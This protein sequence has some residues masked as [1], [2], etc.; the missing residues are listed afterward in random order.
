MFVRRTKS[1]QTDGNSYHTHRLV[2]SERDGGRVRQRTLLN[3]GRHFDIDR[4]RTRLTN[5]FSKAMEKHV[6][7]LSVFFTHYSH[8][9]IHKTLRVTP[10]MEAGLS[11]TLRDTAWIA[12]LIDA[13]APKPR[14]PRT[15]RKRGDS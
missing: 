8:C 15:Y 12:G 1:R 9:R 4:E 13:R 2:R 14:R 11:D 5:A 7:T 10:A 6:A 3:L